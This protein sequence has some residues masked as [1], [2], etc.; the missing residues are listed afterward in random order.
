MRL[1]D[2]LREPAEGKVSASRL[3]LL[4]WGL[5]VFLIW[6]YASLRLG[7]LAEI[8]Q[9]VLTVLGIVVGGKTVQRFGEGRS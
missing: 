3:L 9:S 5:G 6:A 7:A 4:V 2:C 8:P 1:T